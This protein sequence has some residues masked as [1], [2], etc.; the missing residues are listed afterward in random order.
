[1]LCTV[2][3]WMLKIR[4]PVLG[5]VWIAGEGCGHAMLQGSTAW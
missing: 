4:L 1:M 5:G 2:R 3:K